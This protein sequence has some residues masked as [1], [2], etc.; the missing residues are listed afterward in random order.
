MLARIG[1]LATMLLSLSGAAQT[2]EL[3]LPS[4]LPPH[5]VTHIRPV[6]A[7]PIAGVPKVRPAHGA[8]AADGQTSR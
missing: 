5:K 4:K 6:N 1:I 3:D 7:Q 2:A 8:S